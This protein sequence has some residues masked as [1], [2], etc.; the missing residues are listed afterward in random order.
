M[1]K[2]K[3]KTQGEVHGAM[4]G[5]SKNCFGKVREDDSCVVGLKSKH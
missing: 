5:L 1:N 4:R 3:T 2:T